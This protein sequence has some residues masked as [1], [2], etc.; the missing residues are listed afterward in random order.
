MERSE[1]YFH[2]L[3]KTSGEREWGK[4]LEDIL[5]LVNNELNKELIKEVSE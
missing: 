4:V 3:F 5:V 2:E 1:E